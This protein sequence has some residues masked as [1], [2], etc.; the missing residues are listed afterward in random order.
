MTH[1]QSFR[2]DEL[3]RGELANLLKNPTLLLALEIARKELE[4]V[5]AKLDDPEIVSVRLNTAKAHRDLMVGTLHRL[6][7]PLDA[8]PPEERAEYDQ[9]P[10]DEYL[11]PKK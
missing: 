1:E 4:G 9:S 5:D 6:S 8:Q 11:P 10:E 3:K 7:T 2:S